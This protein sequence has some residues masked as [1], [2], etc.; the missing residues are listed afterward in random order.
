MRKINVILLLINKLTT[1][2]DMVLK[3]QCWQSPLL[4]LSCQMFGLTCTLLCGTDLGLDQTA[5]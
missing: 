3:Q 2:Q 1:G 5:L 4:T